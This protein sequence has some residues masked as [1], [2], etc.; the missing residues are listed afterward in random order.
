MHENEEMDYN[1]KFDLGIW[2]KLYKIL[3]TYK[4][5]LIK[6]VSAMIVLAIAESILPIMN[7][8]AIDD[9]I[10]NDTYEGIEWFITGYVSLILIVVVTVFLFIKYAG[11]IQIQLAFDIRQQAFDKLQHLSYSFFD[12]NNVGW[13]MSRVTSDTRRISHILSWGVID[14][15]FSF[16]NMFIIACV[17]MYFNMRLALIVLSVTPILFIV[18]AYL[19]KKILVE[20][21]SVRKINSK[22]TGLFNEGIGGAKTTKTL[23]LE[24]KNLKKFNG[25]AKGLRKS[26]VRAAMFSALM[27]PAVIVVG[28]TATSLGFYFGGIE[29]INEVI[30]V[31]VLYLF[32][33]YSIRF[34]E[35]IMQVA[36]IFAEMQQAQASAERVLGLIDTENEITDT[37]EVV[38]KY[39]TLENPKTENYEAL[40]GDIKFENVTFK[41]KTGEQVLTDFNLDIKAGSSVA[42]VGHTGAGKSTIVNLI[43]RFYEPTEGKIYIDGR[44][45]KDRSV[46]WL[47]SNLGYVLQ[48]PHLFSGTIR[49]NIRYG[50]LDA[51]D[52]EVE[53][54][55]K[56][57]NIDKIVEKFEKGYDTEVGEGGS[58]LSVGEKQLVSF[59]RALISD[60]SIMIL[61]E[62]TSSIDTET[63]QLIQEAIDKMLE[64]RTSFII[65]HR[66][67]TI[68]SSDLILV[69]KDGEIIE[70]GTHQELIDLKGRYYKLYTN[71]FVE[72]QT[73]RIL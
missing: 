12:T 60:P 34:I 47:H 67:S 68:V 52:A 4:S 65:A 29:V 10:A 11:R 69:L 18:V 58:K 16:L 1:T 49:E 14:I 20:Y 61:D 6:G 71:Q 48:S 39:G 44:D 31:G 50:K 2:K 46:G 24:N 51:T 45:Y 64:G 28:Y 13:L 23:N 21:R 54:I 56:V 35:P 5:D 70:S 32:I 25:E 38:E 42:L 15:V 33:T 53:A 72:E 17:M 43:C 27:S 59:A 63:E 3:I 62:A 19:R 40:G 73:S 37:D 36:A 66:L 57:V 55:A 26:S 8:F 41:Y 7:K 30:E 9:F 22:I